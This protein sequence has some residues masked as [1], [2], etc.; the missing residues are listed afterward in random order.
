MSNLVM[1][2]SLS[3][4]TQHILASYIKTFRSVAYIFLEYSLHLV[5]TL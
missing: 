1:I 4:M 5:K 3:H 2:L